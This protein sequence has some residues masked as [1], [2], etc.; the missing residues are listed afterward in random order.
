MHKFPIQFEV[1]AQASSGISNKWESS[2]KNMNCIT[3]AI[4]AE[5]H[6]PGKAY[7]PEDLFG[8]GILNCV[9]AVFKNL[10]QNNN[11][12]FKKIDSK[13]NIKLDRKTGN[14]ELVITN[15]EFF[16]NVYGSSDAEK[17]RLF[18]EQSFRISPIANAVN[19][20]KTYHTTIN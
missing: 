13:L 20:G 3:V 5:L 11:I 18:L 12:D 8:L 4:P 16:I 15:L 7:S 19:T 6:G 10:C 17:A 2:A 14:D 9:I 1:S